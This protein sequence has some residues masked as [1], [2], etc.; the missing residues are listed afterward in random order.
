[1]SD[2]WITRQGDGLYPASDSDLGIIR[3]LPIGKPMQGSA[4]VPR[5][6]KFH[7]KAFGLLNLA[8]SY[9]EPKTLVS[10]VESRTVDNL[11]NYMAKHGVSGEAI[12]ALCSGFLS[13]LN[14]HRMHYETGKDF[15]SFR[16]WI[17]VKAG[18]FTI[19]Q[20]PAGVRKIAK[21]ISFANMDDADFASYYKAILDQCWILCLHSVFDNQEQ[22]ANQLLNF[23]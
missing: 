21:S 17:T 14:D 7:R 12:D 10:E 16:E 6:L 13:H 18:F 19:V 9:W 1:M 11:K 15:A 20:T 2:F 22:L 8:F 5:N 4:T 3:K 23:E